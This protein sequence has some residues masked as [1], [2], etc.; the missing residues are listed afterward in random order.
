MPELTKEQE[1][2]MLQLGD[3]ESDHEIVSSE[4]VDKLVGLGFLF[5]PEEGHLDFTDAGEEIYDSLVKRR[6]EK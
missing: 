6:K 1:A 5:R 2:V 4:V 3:T